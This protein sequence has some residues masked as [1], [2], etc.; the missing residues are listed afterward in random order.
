MLS[1]AWMAP[2]ASLFGGFDGP[3]TVGRV[4][5]LAGATATAGGGA[6]GLW[7]LYSKLSAVPPTAPAA[8]R[9]FLEGACVESGWL[10]LDEAQQ[11][12]AVLEAE[13]GFR[14]SCDRALAFAAFN[15]KAFC[16]VLVACAEVARYSCALQY[17]VVAHTALTPQLMGV[18][19]GK[20]PVALERFK[21]SITPAAQ[22]DFD[23]V[24]K[25]IANA[26]SWLHTGARLQTLVEF[27]RQAL[28]GQA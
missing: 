17:G 11:A 27:E 6:A 21:A 22:A 7:V 26:A 20:I 8:F 13:P 1:G 15:R 10:S 2:V 9:A 24:E 23:D 3:W 19:V 28:A 4:A 12:A 14:E 25:E 18:R 5:K 16:Q